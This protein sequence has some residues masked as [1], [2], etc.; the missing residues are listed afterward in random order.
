MKNKVFLVISM[1]FLLVQ[2]NSNVLLALVDQ[3]LLCQPPKFAMAAEI[4]KEGL[5]SCQQPGTRL[6]FAHRYF[7][8]MSECGQETD[9]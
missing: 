8:F 7:H 2:N 9:R 1:F 5:D 4:L 6:M 3:A